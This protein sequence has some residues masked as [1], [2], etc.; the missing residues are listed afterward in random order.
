MTDVISCQIRKVEGGFIATFPGNSLSCYAERTH[1]FT[2]WGDLLLALSHE[3]HE[4]EVGQ[5]L[6]DLC[7]KENQ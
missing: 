1:I 4:V 5:S 2:N 3:A 6:S 7:E